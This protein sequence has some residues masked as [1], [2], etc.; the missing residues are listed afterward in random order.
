[1]L[2][3]ARE[4]VENAN[5]ASVT[6]HQADFRTLL[7]EEN[8]FDVIL[9]GAVFHHL[10]GDEDWKSAFARFH[11]WLKPGGRIYVADLCIFGLPDLQEIMWQRY[12]DYLVALYGEACREKVFAHIDKEDSPRSLPFQLNLLKSTGF[13]GYAPIISVILKSCLCNQCSQS[14]LLKNVHAQ[15]L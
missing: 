5:A 6:T 2:N 8:C 13:S 1:M 14:H 3:R 9:A 11:R 4:R 15:N 10:R 12:G 7:F